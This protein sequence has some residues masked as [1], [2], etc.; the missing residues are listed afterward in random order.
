MSIAVKFSELPA[1]VRGRI[2]GSAPK[3]TKNKVMAGLRRAQDEIRRDSFFKML[4]RAHLPLP[5]PEHQFHETRKWRFDFAWLPE[6]VALE[7]EGGIYSGGAHTRGKHFE[8]DAL[9]YNTATVMGWRI[10]RVT[11]EHLYDRAT[12]KMLKAVLR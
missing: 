2:R 11:P 9:K 1:D 5:T 7:V 3:R 12:E 10:L 4:E 8:S 6:K